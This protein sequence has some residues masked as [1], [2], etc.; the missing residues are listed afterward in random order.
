MERREKIYQVLKVGSIGI[1]RHI[2]IKAEA[3]PYLPEFAKYFWRRRHVKESK[4]LPGLS[5][6]EHRA[7]ATA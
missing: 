3:N 1:R 5:A 7:M 4:L 2:K 6:R